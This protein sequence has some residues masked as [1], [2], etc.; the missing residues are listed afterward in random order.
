M[1]DKMIKALVLLEE[2]TRV[3]GERLE[4]IEARLKELD[5]EEKEKSLEKTVTKRDHVA[6]QGYK[7]KMG[8]A[9]LA[10][11]ILWAR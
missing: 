2:R 3:I 1:T 11:E 4:R 6:P 8:R 5:S 9:I 7:C 10:L